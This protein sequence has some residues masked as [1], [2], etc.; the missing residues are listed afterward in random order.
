[1]KICAIG[2][3]RCNR[4]CPL[5]SFLGYQ[6]HSVAVLIWP[7]GLCWVSLKVM[8]SGMTAGLECLFLPT[9]N[10]LDIL[11]FLQSYA[12]YDT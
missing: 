7:K 4:V 6:H 11:F 10:R 5:E 1:V 12:G 9:H 2:C 3:N 8:V